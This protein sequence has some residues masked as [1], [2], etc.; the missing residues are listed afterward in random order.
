MSR[1]YQYAD[2]NDKTGLYLL[3]GYKGQ[4]T[5]FQVS[6]LGEKLFQHLD[7][8][9][10]VRNQKQGPRIPDKI[11]WGLFE[12]DWIYTN[13]SG[14]TPPTNNV[15]DIIT[16]NNSVEIPEE[17]AEDLKTYLQKSGGSDVEELAN[18]LEL[19]ISNK[20]ERSGFNFSASTLEN[21]R[22]NDTTSANISDIHGIAILVADDINTEIVPTNN[23][24]WEITYINGE[25]LEE[26]KIV[27][28]KIENRHEPNEEFFH[29]I[30][31][32]PGNRI[33]RITTVTN[34]KIDWNQRIQLERQRGEIIESFIS[35]TTNENMDIGN[36]MCNMELSIEYGTSIE[37]FG[38]QLNI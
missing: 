2:S 13:E 25:K 28:I 16:R 21:H 1:L 14:V 31:I 26:D 37:Q 12:I 29:R 8:Q 34:K 10:G 38:N 15:G 36:P 11:H 30:S 24:E 5:T 9:P 4:N 35:V 27:I 17:V 20:T 6:T 3:D 22:S 33:E 7:Y 32:S 19:D 18:I 23:A